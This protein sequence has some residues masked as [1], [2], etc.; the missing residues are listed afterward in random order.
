MSLDRMG[1]SIERERPI[2]LT[3]EEV[4][5]APAN[6]PD[7]EPRSRSKRL[8]RVMN[9]TIASLALVLAS[10]VMLLFAVVVKLTSQGPIFY[11]QPRVG[12]DRR[13]SSSGSKTYD[14]RTRDLGGL[15]FMI[16][17][18]RTMYIGAEIRHAAVWATRGDARI[19]PFGGL[20]RKLRIDE[21]PQLFNVINGDMSIVGPRPERPSI[22]SRL[23][24]DIADYPLR[25]RATP[26][27]TGWA[28]INQSYDTNID[29]VRRKVRYDLEYMQRRGV[30][31]DLMIMAKT[32]PVLLL[33]KGGW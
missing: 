14:R 31:K 22:F 26:G 2:P 20:M 33:R 29:D 32:V 5:L 4:R 12:I 21:L 8:D 6:S 15:P 13:R 1:G 25:Q 28:Q 19:T 17:K 7:V 23:R 27:I 18:F 11:S 10:P 24:V 30:R 9:I 3:S 16:Y